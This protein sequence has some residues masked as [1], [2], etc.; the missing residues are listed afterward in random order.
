MN[1]IVSRYQGFLV[2]QLLAGFIALVMVLFGNFGGY[3]YQTSTWEASGSVGLGTSLLDSALVGFLA[4]G[5]ALSL[6]A[7]V[8]TLQSS[9]VTPER[10]TRNTVRATRGALFTTAVAMVGAIVFVALNLESTYWWFDMGFYGAVVGGGLVA[11]LG[12]LVSG[13]LARDPY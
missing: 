9:E 3:Y 13:D 8:S 12:K 10:F 6:Y 1:E 2:G 5:L 7:T 11:Y 4:I